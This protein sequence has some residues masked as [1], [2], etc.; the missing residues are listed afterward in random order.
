MGLEAVKRVKDYVERS[1]GSAIFFFQLS[2]LVLVLALLCLS[3]FMLPQDEEMDA[4]AF[5]RRF[6]AHATEA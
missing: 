3:I 4:A 1:G 5:G 2:L 6:M